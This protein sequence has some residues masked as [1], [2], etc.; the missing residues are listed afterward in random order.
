MKIIEEAFRG[1]HSDY[2]FKKQKFHID[3]TPYF[4]YA[5][6]MNK[7]ECIKYAL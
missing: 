5:K 6:R 2:I 1:T 3:S 7:R 4:S